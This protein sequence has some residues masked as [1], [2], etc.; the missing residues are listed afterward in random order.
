MEVVR[1]E[2]KSID[3]EAA[4]V[5]EGIE[6]PQKEAPVVV[7]EED[8]LLIIAPL[9]DMMEGPG[10]VDSDRSHKGDTIDRPKSSLPESENPKSD[11]TL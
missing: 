4:L 3:L 10:E 7:I 2:A 8:V 1:H 5:L 11:L 9:I 6:I